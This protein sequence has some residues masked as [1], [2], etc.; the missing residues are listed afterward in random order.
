MWGGELSDGPPL[1]DPRPTAEFL[2]DYG[3]GPAI[4]K[5]FFR[6]FYGGVFLEQELN[7]AAGMFAFT[8]DMFAHGHACVPALGMEQIPKQIAAKLAPETVELQHA[9]RGLQEG[10]ALDQ[11]GRKIDAD[12]TVLATDQSTTARFLGQQTES[13]W[14]GTRCFYFRAPEAPT[15]TPILYLNGDETGILSSAH[16]VTALSPEAGPHAA[17]PNDA[18]ISATVKGDAETEESLT[19]AV[20]N[21]LSVWFGKP[22]REWKLLRDYHIAE[23]LPGSA[24]TAPGQAPGFQAID[25]SLFVCGDHLGGASINGALRSGR[26]LAERL[27]QP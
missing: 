14:R 24:S 21:E 7:S 12:V 4:I 1:S 13:K 26:L 5:H 8:F 20:A 16:V 23:S 17:A 3:F 27:A 22:A 11:S 9:V 10:R 2:T 25:S 19:E 6:P 15:R 18:L